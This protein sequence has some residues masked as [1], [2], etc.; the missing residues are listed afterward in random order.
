M[1]IGGTDTATTALKWAL[2]ELIH[3]LEIMK[4]AQEE[5]DKVVGRHR[6]VLESNLHNLPYLHAI[7]K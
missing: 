2:S 4:K 1:I 3:H 6:L 5:L 7:V